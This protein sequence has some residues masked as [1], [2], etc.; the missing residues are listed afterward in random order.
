MKINF[1]GGFLII[2]AL[3]MLTGIACAIKCIIVEEPGFGFGAFFFLGSA[4]ACYA[5]ERTLDIWE[6]N[7]RK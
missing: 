2:G 5:L 1:T 3:F 4:G 7:N 6:K